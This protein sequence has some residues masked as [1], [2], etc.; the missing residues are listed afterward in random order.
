MLALLTH[1]PLGMARTIG[2]T[3]NLPDVSDQ[4]VGTGSPDRFNHAALTPAFSIAVGLCS[5]QKWVHG[6]RR[7]VVGS[8]GIELAAGPVSKLYPDTHTRSVSLG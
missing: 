1:S 3:V 8:M 7:G 6:S 4:L 5:G 2:V